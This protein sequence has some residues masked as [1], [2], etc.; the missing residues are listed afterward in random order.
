VEAIYVCNDPL[1]TTNRVRISTLA[2]AALL[3]TMFIAREY[4]E[5]GGLMSYGA[6]FQDL[7]RR[8]AEFVDKILRG[9][10]PADIPVEQPTRFDLIINLTTAKALGLT[11]P[12]MLLSRADEVI[13]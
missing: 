12:P 7:Y 1:A 8:T 10:K 4:V 3:P 6:N 9:T 5:A 13:E 11:I 2:S